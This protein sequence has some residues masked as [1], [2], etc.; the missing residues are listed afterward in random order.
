MELRRRR[1]ESIVMTLSTWISLNMYT[2]Q[3]TPFPLKHSL[4]SWQDSLVISSQLPLSPALGPCCSLQA[5]LCFHLLTLSIHTDTYTE[6]LTYK[7]NNKYLKYSIICCLWYKK[8]NHWASSVCFK[9]VVV[10][11][12]FASGFDTK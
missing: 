7:L 5:D 6:A 1:F 3:T 4:W 12:L 2:D 10:I 11:T 9:Y 8:M